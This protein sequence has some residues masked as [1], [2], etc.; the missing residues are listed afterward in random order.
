MDANFQ[1]EETFVFT[2]TPKSVGKKRANRNI[3][4]KV[5][6]YFILPI[7]YPRTHSIYALRPH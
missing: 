6:Y 2:T 5:S 7:P 3:F 4:W 1:G